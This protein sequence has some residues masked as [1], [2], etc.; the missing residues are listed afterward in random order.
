LVHAGGRPRFKPIPITATPTDLAY[1]AGFFDGEGTIYYL[2][3]GKHSYSII[4]FN[5]TDKPVLDWIQKTLKVLKPPIME[6]LRIRNDIKANKNMWKLYINS[7]ANVSLVLEALL[8]YLKV[9][10]EL[11]KE[12]LKTLSGNA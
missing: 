7:Q 12:H 8:P 1:I 6:P 4:V 3:E 11:S 10:K 9:K 2:K 5:N